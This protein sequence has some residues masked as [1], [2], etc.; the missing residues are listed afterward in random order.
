MDLRRAF[1]PF[2]QALFAA[3]VLFASAVLFAA[4]PPSNPEPP[5]A[6]TP[7]ADPRRPS[8]RKA[9][10]PK[11]TPPPV[12][13]GT[14][15]GGDGRPIEGARVYYLPLRS[16]ATES[17][18][19]VRT[20]AQ[21][22][23]RIDLPKP[24]AQM[25]RVEARG[26]ASRRLDK[27][28][29][30]ARTDIVL[31]KG[32]AIDG[33]VVD[34]AGQPV[35]GARVEARSV[36]GVPS[37]W[38]A[39]AG[40][41]STRTDAAGRFRIEGLDASLQR[42]FAWSGSGRAVKRAV[43]GGSQIVLTLKP[44]GVLSGLVTD[45]SGRALEGVLVRETKGPHFWGEG[46]GDTSDAGGRFEIVGLDAGTYTV[47]AH[48]PDFAPAFQQDVRVELRGRSD[49]T[50]VLHPGVPVAGRLVDAA[51]KPVA[52]RLRVSE[53][54]ERLPDALGDLLRAESGVDGRF[55]LSRVAPGDYVFVVNAPGY[56]ARRA[57]VS[58]SGED[59]AVDLG[60]IVLD[61][62]LAIRGHVRS[63]SG[64]PVADATVAC[65]QSRLSFFS[66]W[67]TETRSLDDGSFTLA[68]LQPGHCEVSAAAPGYAKARV[69]AEV[70]AE[71]VVLT[72]DAAGSLT[73]VV[74]E[75]GDRPVEA[76][77]VTLQLASQSQQRMF[78]DQR[79]ESIGTTDGRFSLED[80]SEG[81]YVLQ[82]LVPDRLPSVANNLSVSAGRTTDAGV[83]RV[84]R[85]GIVRGTVASASGGVVGATVR[86]QGPGQDMLT[87]S[88][89]FMTETDAGGTFEFRGAPPGPATLKATHPD[90]ASASASVEV[91]PQKAPADVRIVLSEG[92][93]LEGTVR[94]RDGSPL[95]GQRVHIWPKTGGSWN[96]EPLVTGADGAFGLDHVPVGSVS[97][98]LMA[99]TGPGTF[100][101]A[102]SAEA[103]VREG[104]TT[105][106]ALFSRDI[107]VSGRA[108][109]AGAP[110][111][112]LRIELIGESTSMIVMGGL[113]DTTEA[114]P[115]GPERLRAL[116]RDDGSFE[117][118][119][120]GPG[121]YHATCRQGTA[122]FPG[123]TIDIPDAETYAFDLAF[124]G[125][126]VSGIVLDKDSSAPVPQA[127]VSANSDASTTSPAFS[128]T[129]PDGRFEIEVEP[130]RLR[131]SAGARG[132]VGSNVEVDVP[133]SG[134][135]DLRLEITK[136]LAINGRL[137]DAAG[138]G[139]SGVLVAAHSRGPEVVTRSW[140]T[141]GDGSFTLDGLRAGSYVLCGGNEVAG[142]AVRSGI[143][144]GTSDLTL[145]TRPA[146]SVRL[147]VLGADGAPVAGA[148]AR[149]S[150]IGGV[151]AEVPVYG[152]GTSDA[153]GEMSIKVPSGTLDITV[154]REET[155]AVASVRVEPGGSA[156]AEVRLAPHEKKRPM[157]A[158]ERR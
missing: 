128:T 12:V 102:D 1:R 142:Y 144:A 83:I 58:V 92:G 35:G 25:L 63:R 60:D 141:L 5:A 87:W 16:T 70:G 20:D 14:V 158:F 90:Y 124:S 85:G 49:I 2:A 118:I 79:A 57:D 107:L 150:K 132:Y 30:G 115:T 54:G 147:L 28:E 152:S 27:V 120:S 131:L 80:L 67:P 81:R 77:Q 45:A 21:G 99:S 3:A 13:E 6:K 69:P 8:V 100:A 91:D 143:A 98:I 137:V 145:T 23:F 88:E 53:A 112:G 136:G 153:A 96:V 125:T 36:R 117:M 140:Q 7:P 82:V 121:R 89:A 51:E 156:V 62:G 154:A 61:P 41:V 106:V 109:R 29:P 76:Y 18:R 32:R 11:P 68:G 42:V 94:R 55:L 22:R 129:G 155:S 116:T 84:G 105:T 37:F 65:T 119:V 39:E 52:G 47:M 108:T 134:T 43:R 130:G 10:A 24:T 103:V 114:T 74:V 110:L 122:G 86:L 104:E 139:L 64:A 146:A 33:V 26:W 138:R 46:L 44:L 101:S 38:D 50:L 40:V 19:V 157:P 15:K 97:V 9:P 135:S 113:G 149:V 56:A 148:Y 71:R 111:A 93:R 31:D 151:D 4:A 17:A 75:E 34:E 66:G 95:A 123:R 73:G 127:G 78:E 59:P 133:E 48:H 126:A 72:L